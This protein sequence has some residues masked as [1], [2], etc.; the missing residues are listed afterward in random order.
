MNC[1]ICKIINQIK[2]KKDP[3]FVKELKT[4]YVV[5]GYNQFYYG[6]A[7]FLSKVHARELHELEPAFKKKFL[8]EMS[9][10]AEAVFKTFKP[11]KLNYELLGNTEEHMH[12][13]IFPRRSTDPLS[14]TGVWAVSK[15]IRK[16][17]NTIPSPEKLT[18]MKTDLL[19][20]I[21]NLISNEAR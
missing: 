10:V 14:H 19:F 21:N 13:H 16:A 20:S 15:E 12:W 17:E 9:L 1:L 6:Y 2:G 18:Q 4:G 8:E 11:E 5:I 7:L 3:Y